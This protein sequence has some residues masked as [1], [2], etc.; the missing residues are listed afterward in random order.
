MHLE[1][2]ANIV[3]VLKCMYEN[4]EFFGLELYVPISTFLHVLSSVQFYSYSAKQSPQG[5]YIR[6]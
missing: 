2:N 4:F 1:E 6:N 5:A 3:Y